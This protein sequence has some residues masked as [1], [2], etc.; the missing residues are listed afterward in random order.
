MTLGEKRDR[1][2]KHCESVGDCTDCSLYYK[3]PTKDN[4]YEDIMLVP[5]HYE[6]L[7]GGDSD[8]PYWN[9]IEVIAKRQRDK[10]I[11]TYGQGLE[12]NPL[13]IMKRIEHLEEE[14]IDGLMYCEWIKEAIKERE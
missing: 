13:A 12:N 1:I 4:C 5:K 10:G 8:N 11:K 9:R 7:F 6:I 2:K 14:L 3:I